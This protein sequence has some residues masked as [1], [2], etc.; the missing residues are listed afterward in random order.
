MSTIHVHELMT[1]APVSVGP[2][3]NLQQVRELMDAHDIRHLPV[4][5][6]DGSVVGLVSQR[7]FIR[8]ALAP[9]EGLTLSAQEDVLRAVTV[10]TV[11]TTDVAT[12]EPDAEVSVAGQIMLDNKYGCLPVV[13]DLR[14][15]GILTEAD[16]VR[17]LAAVA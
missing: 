5:D 1:E 6:D 9:A 15:T 11:M 14:L 7:D 13:E 2:D 10:G 4:V 8:F 16:F 12:V 17:Y 3:D